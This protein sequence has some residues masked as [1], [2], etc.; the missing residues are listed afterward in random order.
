M[1]FCKGIGWILEWSRCGRLGSNW[2]RRLSGGSS[3]RMRLRVFRK[4]FGF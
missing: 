3:W 4:K 2:M 1:R